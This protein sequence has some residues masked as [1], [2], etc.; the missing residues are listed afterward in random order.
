MR[1]A[2]ALAPA[3]TAAAMVATP[4][5]GQRT[6]G[7]R[8]MSSVVVAGLFATTAERAAHRWGP[9]RA[10]L[11]TGA[12]A[13]ATAIVE[14]VGV[15][16]GRPFG[17]YHYTGALQPQIGGVPVI[18]PMAWFAMALPARE[19][20][21]AV[22]GDRSSAVSRIV[23]GAAALTAWDAFLDPQMVAEGYWEWQQPGV[24]RTIPLRN[25]LGWFM[26]GLGVMAVLEVLVP[27]APHAGRDAD[28]TMVGQYAFM[29][30]METVGFAAFFKDRVVA[31]V[32]GA[33]MLPL[34]TVAVVRLVRGR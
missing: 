30:V 8:A 1:W 12:I 10:G 19:V 3:I 11:A 24:Y 16:T 5:M 6:A 28:R 22:T 13:A 26:T 27:P 18:V 33:A 15:R 34:G 7:R 29:A 23:I 31:A 2:R 14:R 17:R 25:Y 32:G 9:G 20:A 4:L 21:V